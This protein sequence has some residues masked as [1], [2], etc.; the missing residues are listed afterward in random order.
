MTIDIKSRGMVL[1]ENKFIMWKS[2]KQ[3]NEEINEKL[4][5]CKIAFI[6]IKYLIKDIAFIVL[7]YAL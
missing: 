4:Y 5:S 2:E 7:S 3:Y 1:Y 6:L